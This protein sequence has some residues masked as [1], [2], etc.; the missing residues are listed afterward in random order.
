EHVCVTQPFRQRYRDVRWWGQAGWCVRYATESQRI[1]VSMEVDADSLQHIRDDSRASVVLNGPLSNPRVNISV[2]GRGPQ[3]GDGG[4]LQTTS[5]LMEDT[6]ALKDQIDRLG[7]EVDRGLIGLSALTD[8]LSDE[9]TKADIEALKTHVAAVKEQIRTATGLVGAVLYDPDTRS[10]MSRTLREVKQS[11]EDAQE[12][13][14]TLERKLKRTM[15]DVERTA[16]KI[17]TLSTSLKDPDNTSLVAVLVNDQHGLSEQGTRLA[18]NTEEALGAGREAI[19][20]MDAVL[21][22]VM[23]ALENREG[24]LGRLFYDPKPLY[25]IKDPATMRRVNVVKRLSRWV[26]EADEALGNPQAV[27]RE[28]QDE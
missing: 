21:G 23:R 10:E 1:R 27:P 14:T 11:A 25:H 5:S 2:G 9:G 4:R 12:E 8:A 7:E 24:T 20:D 13:Y 18:D 17:E 16:G 28:P 6:L 26:I 22:E 15:K 19:A 3:I